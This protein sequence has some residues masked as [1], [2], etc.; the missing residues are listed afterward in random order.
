MDVRRSRMSGRRPA[1]PAAV[2]ASL[3]AILPTPLSGQ[4]GRIG[5]DASGESPGAGVIVAAEPGVSG[6]PGGSRTVGPATASE[7]VDPSLLSALRYRFVGPTRGGR[8][9]AVAGHR[10]HPATFYMGSTGGGV[11][12]TDDNGISW[13]NLSDGFFETAPIGVIRVAE[14]NPNVVWVG[15]GS[16]GIR[17]N[18]IIG[19][20]MYR[21]DD[22]GESWRHVGLSNAGQIG[23]MVVHPQDPDVAW[24]AAIGSPFGKNP[25]RGV[26]RTRDGGDTW[27]QL[28]HHSDSVGVYGLVAEPG[29]PDVLYMSTWRGERKPWTIISGME[30][31]AGRGST[32]PPTAERAGRSSP[33][34]YPRGWWGRSTSPSPRR[35]PGGSTPSWRPPATNSGCTSRRMPGARGKPGATSGAHGPALLLHQHPHRPHQPGQGLRQR[36][37]VVGVRRRGRTFERRPTPHGDNHDMW[38]NPDNS[39]HFIQANDGGVNVTL[40]GGRSW[41]TQNN[42]P[43]AELY[44]VDMDDAFPYWLYAGQQDNT[45]IA[46]PSQIP[47]VTSPSGPEGLWREVG[48][49]ETG[50]SVPRPGD[51]DI[52][53]ASC[54][55]RF[56]RFNMRTGQEKQYYV[57]PP[58]CTATT[59]PTSSSG[60]S[61]R[62]R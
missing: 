6:A 35:P 30:A 57:G 40:D 39:D 56:G 15:T 29:N 20:G 50:P 32:S 59:R 12:K 8:V 41:S 5:A 13:Y 36:H 55:G 47:A 3:L 61:G 4:E 62:C 26:Y 17:S 31:S 9:T 33:A 49:C 7:T 53:Y 11:W 52:I 34:A 45:T 1:L 21:S 37:P 43:T 58:T 46:V 60:C 48:G 51:P 10:S 27:Q 25:E 18:I 54:K 19:R 23:R 28:Y 16:D 14:S 38:I 22:A 44:Q 2:L 42:Q 24:V